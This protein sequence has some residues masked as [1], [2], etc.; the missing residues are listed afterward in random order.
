MTALRLFPVALA[1]A[2][3]TV[4]AV[5]AGASPAQGAVIINEILADPASDWDGDGAVD[6]RGDEWIEVLN[7][8][9]DA[10]DLTA[11]WL[12]DDAVT[13]PRLNLFGILPAGEAAVF[14]G[15]QAVAWQEE[16]GQTTAGFALNNGGDRVVLLRTVA[17]SDPLALEDVDQADFTDHQAEDDRS[18]GWST[19]RSAW[20][21]FDALL[22][23]T[24]SLEPQGTGC[25]PTPG[26]PNAC[27]EEVGVQA[28]SLGSLKAA[29]R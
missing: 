1:L 22:P 17:G 12:R 27:G 29:Y 23:Y 4:A 21:L 7:T 13:T 15:S 25:P 2:V 19:D 6:A 24:G 18:C 10:V 16:V 5:L 3:L 11:Y 8:G 20:R 26:L 9:P 28:T 14:Y